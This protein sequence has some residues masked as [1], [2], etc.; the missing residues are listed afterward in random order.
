MSR[1][2][3]KTLTSLFSNAFSEEALPRPF[4]TSI[5]LIADTGLSSTIFR[6]IPPIRRIMIDDRFADKYPRYLGVYF[7]TRLEP[8]PGTEDVDWKSIGWD[9]KPHMMLFPHIPPE[10]VILHEFGHYLD[11]TFIRAVHHYC[12]GAYYTTTDPSCAPIM[13]SLNPDRLDEFSDL[14]EDM[15]REFNYIQQVAKCEVAATSGDNA[16]LSNLW[17]DKIPYSTRYRYAPTSYAFVNLAEWFAEWFQSRCIWKDESAI[18]FKAPKTSAFMRFFL[19][20][21]IF[22]KPVQELSYV[23]LTEYP[24][25]E[26]ASED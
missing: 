2:T 9:G 20:G 15:K 17:W 23:P 26:V 18:F 24:L 14:R 16:L 11:D 25:G 12:D 22:R 7:P 8:T 3:H 6:F 19:S 10:W 21:K 1:R 5:R 4:Q 13:E